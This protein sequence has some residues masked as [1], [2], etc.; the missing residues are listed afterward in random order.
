MPTKKTVKKIKGF[1]KAGGVY[2][3]GAVK[4]T[5]FMKAAFDLG[6]RI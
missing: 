3:P 5:K 4:K 2:E 6:M 1:L